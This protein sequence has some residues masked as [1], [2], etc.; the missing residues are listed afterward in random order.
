MKNLLLVTSVIL[1]SQFAKAGTGGYSVT[2]CSSASGRTIV[3]TYLGDENI[4]MNVIVDGKITT[5]DNSN[6]KIKFET[7]FDFIQVLKNDSPQVGLKGT[8][9]NRQLTIITDPRK[10]T[11]IDYVAKP[12]PQTIEVICKTYTKEP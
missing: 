11:D 3:T 5:Y 9:A 10:G 1:L 2:S 7:D 12:G 8:T 6:K 4:I